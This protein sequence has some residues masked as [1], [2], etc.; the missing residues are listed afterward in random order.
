ME[1]D[2]RYSVVKKLIGSGNV[3]TLK[4]IFDVLPKT[5]LARDLGMHHITLNK[6][7]AD[8][9]KFTYA[10]TKKIAQLIEVETNA[11]FQIMLNDCQAKE[12]SAKK[13]KRPKKK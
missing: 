13:T 4:D 12:A 10:D 9:E 8:P 11:I 2:R 1:K 6:L 3:N 5:T 7:L